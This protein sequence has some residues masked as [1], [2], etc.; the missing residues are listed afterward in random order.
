MAHLV[1]GLHHPMDRAGLVNEGRFDIALTQVHFSE[2]LGVSLV[3]PDRLRLS[4]IVEVDQTGVPFRTKASFFDETPTKPI[5]II[6][7]V[8]IIDGATGVTPRKSA[9]ARRITIHELAGSAW[10]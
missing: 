8:E 6:G 7:A 5:I 3:D 4:G 10:P 9:R 2:V 1:L